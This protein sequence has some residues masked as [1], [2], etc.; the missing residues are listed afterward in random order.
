M[1]HRLRAFSRSVGAL[2]EVTEAG[3]DKFIHRVRT[4]ASS[5]DG[6]VTVPATL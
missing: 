2:T 5:L 3:S 6:K 1:W 4:E